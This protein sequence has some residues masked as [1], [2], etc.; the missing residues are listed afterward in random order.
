VVEAVAHS[1]QLRDVRHE[2][3][4]A[5]HIAEDLAVRLLPEEHATHVKARPGGIER[6]ACVS[7]THVQRSAG[8]GHSRDGSRR[9]RL[10]VLVFLRAAVSRDCSSDCFASTAAF[11][12]ATS[13]GERMPRSTRKPLRSKRKRSSAVMPPLSPAAFML[14]YRDAERATL[15]NAGVSERTLRASMHSSWKHRER[16]V[17]ADANLEDKSRVLSYLH[18]ASMH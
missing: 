2:L 18:T 4:V 10:P 17:T 9:G 15:L 7:D 11:A 13:S 6:R 3:G 5:E 16:G 12:A 1:A 8:G 14:M